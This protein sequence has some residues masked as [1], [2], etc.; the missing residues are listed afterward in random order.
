M[1]RITKSDYDDDFGWGGPCR[2]PHARCRRLH[3]GRLQ[4]VHAF[5]LVRAGRG[6]AAR[7]HAPGGPASNELDAS[8]VDDM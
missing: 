4:G 1:N 3:P 6:G 7:R 2:G 5:T 8:V